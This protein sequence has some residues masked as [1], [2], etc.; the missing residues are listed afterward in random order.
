M[1]L[2]F[3]SFEQLEKEYVIALKNFTNDENNPAQIYNNDSYDQLHTYIFWSNEFEIIKF[4]HGKCPKI[5]GVEER[6]LYVKKMFEKYAKNVSYQ[7]NIH[8]IIT[9]DDQEHLEQMSLEQMSNEAHGYICKKHLKIV[10]EQFDHVCNLLEDVKK[11]IDNTFSDL[12]KTNDVALEYPY[13]QKAFRNE[14]LSFMNPFS[15]EMFLLV[16]A[17]INYIQSYKC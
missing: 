10:T 3:S 11:Y 4:L 15:K 7:T 1:S 9:K 14:K 13:I 17:C 6:Y 16:Q 12:T 5:P 2:E 8:G